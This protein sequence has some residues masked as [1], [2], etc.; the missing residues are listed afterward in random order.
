MTPD[1]RIQHGEQLARHLDR[2]GSNAWADSVRG[3]LALI[4]ELQEQHEKDRAAINLNAYAAVHENE[5]ANQN[6]P[7]KASYQEATKRAQ[8]AESSLT[9]LQQA[10]AALIEKHTTLALF[11]RAVLDGYVTG[12]V[13]DIDGGWLQDKAAELGLIVESG[14]DDD[15]N[16]F[17][18]DDLAALA[19][20][21]TDRE[22]K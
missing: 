12:V 5:R 18:C 20:P 7:W 2:T 14:S 16:L 19:V 6:A 13:G 11:A 10:H 8:A 4:A 1:P 3:L 17:L 22:T 21:Q 15:P 9:A